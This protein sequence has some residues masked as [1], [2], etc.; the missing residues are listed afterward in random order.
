MSESPYNFI[1]TGK[2]PLFR[3]RANFYQRRTIKRGMARRPP[4]GHRRRVPPIGRGRR[5]PCG[6]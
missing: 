1:T 5:T 4:I 3:G 6:G 2:G